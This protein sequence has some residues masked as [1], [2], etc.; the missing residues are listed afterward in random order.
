MKS[1]RYKII[2]MAIGLLLTS[3]VW[4][5]VFSI[6]ENPAF[7]PLMGSGLAIGFVIGWGF[8]E[9]KMKK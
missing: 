1:H 9:H 2:G 7:I 8:D 4:L 3:L 6:S 5:F